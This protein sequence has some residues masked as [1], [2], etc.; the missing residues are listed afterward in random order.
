MTKRNHK[1]KSENEIAPHE[2]RIKVNETTVLPREIWI[3]IFTFIPYQQLI[4]KCSLVNHHFHDVILGEDSTSFW[5]HICNHQIIDIIIDLDTVDQVSHFV[6]TNKPTSIKL[7][8]LNFTKLKRNLTYRKKILEFVQVFEPFVT[9]V[10]A[11][12]RFP[13][14]NLFRIYYSEVKRRMFEKLEK[15]DAFINLAELKQWFGTD[16]SRFKQLAIDTDGVKST[17]NLKFGSLEQVRF[18]D[19]GKVES[20]VLKKNLQTIRRV[21]MYLDD[22]DIEGFRCISPVL[23]YL[24]VKLKTFKESV[25]F[26]K[27][28]TLKIIAKPN[29]LMKFFSVT[30]PL[31]TKVIVI[32]Q[33]ITT[34]SRELAAQPSI[35]SFHYIGMST[36]SI[37]SLLKA[38]NPQLLHE[39]SIHSAAEDHVISN[40]DLS[41][42]CN[43]KSI[44]LD[45]Y[46]DVHFNKFDNV[47]KSNQ[48]SSLKLIDSYDLALPC[49]SHLLYLKLKV[50]DKDTLLG[51][52]K[53]PN[54]RSITVEEMNITYSQFTQLTQESNNIIDYI[55]DIFKSETVTPE[56][57]YIINN[58]KK[59]FIH[60]AQNNFAL[61]DSEKWII[62]VVST[63]NVD[64]VNYESFNH[65][66]KGILTHCFSRSIF[67]RKDIFLSP[68]ELVIRKLKDALNEVMEKKYLNI[69][70]EEKT[71]IMNKFEAMFQMERIQDVNKI[72]P[73]MEKLLDVVNTFMVED[74]EQNESD[75]E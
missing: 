33:G 19:C 55:I 14:H 8:N 46:P 51:L 9:T 2:K 59:L 75:D 34:E 31:L 1:R 48:L 63:I 47:L 49:L 65:V 18:F 36:S 66:V 7:F 39:L 27:L 11:E 30:H 54:L 3:E 67:N 58:V 44:D 52:M 20:D 74:E 38:M 73:A 60:N 61:L 62:Y 35:S 21:K 56:S 4:L 69:N 40:I 15:C 16:L 5:S 72:H 23:T 68:V 29:N 53:L 32:E 17:L 25:T 57:I 41:G 50:L 43:L 64:E 26:S 22:Y 13:F 42:F 24:H 28:H 12:R 37:N 45:A 70:D 71:M 10:Y 6:T